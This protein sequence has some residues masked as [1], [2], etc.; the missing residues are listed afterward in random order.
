[1]VKSV[2]NKDAWD[3]E[4]AIPIKDLDVTKIKDGDSWVMQLVSAQDPGGNYYAWAP[5]TW[6]QFHAFPEIVFDSKA[7]AVQ[8]TGVGDWMNGNPDFRFK[9]FNS[10]AAGRRDQHRRED[11]RTPTARSCSIGPSR[12]RSSPANPGKHT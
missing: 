3:Q 2:F 10:Q 6:L 4:I 11:R 5:A 8:F 7:V 12:R 1:M 9:M